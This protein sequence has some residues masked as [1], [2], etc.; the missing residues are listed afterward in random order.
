MFAYGEPLFSERPFWFAKDDL[1][2]DL[3]RAEIHSIRQLF[4]RHPD[5]REF[6]DLA[7][8]T[9]QQRGVCFAVLAHRALMD[10]IYETFAARYEQ[11][12]SLGD[13]ENDVLSRTRSLVVADAPAWVLEVHQ[14][15]ELL[16]SRLYDTLPEPLRR[17]GFNTSDE[18]EVEIINAAASRLSKLQE[19]QALMGKVVD[20]QLQRLEKRWSATTVQV[21]EPAAPKKSKRELKGMEGLKRKKFDFSKYM[22]SLTDK[23]ELAFSLKN[24]YGLPLAEVA[25]R[26]GVDRKTAWE[27]IQAAA[28]KIDHVRSGEK[29]RANRAKGTIEH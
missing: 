12:S 24:E 20:E 15:A 13:E 6:F 4:A 10:E 26:M 5:L 7:E 27:H 16:P 21:R 14:V 18:A 17:G 22:H 25:S 23:Q 3:L 19:I 9:A 28:T 29:R 8:A 1:L 2:T 11:S